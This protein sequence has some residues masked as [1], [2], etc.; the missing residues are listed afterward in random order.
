MDTDR[1]GKQV[2]TRKAASRGGRSKEKLLGRGGFA[3]VGYKEDPAWSDDL[4]VPDYVMWDFDE[5]AGR[6]R[7]N[8]GAKP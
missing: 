7:V 2:E 4:A 1:S 3:R 6:Q 8:G 5:G